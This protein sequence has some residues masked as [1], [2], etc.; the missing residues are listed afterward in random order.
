M[1]SFIKKIL[2]ANLFALLRK[3]W[4]LQHKVV[5][6][7]QQFKGNGITQQ[8]LTQQLINAGITQGTSVL[9]HSSL[10][11]LGY[12]ANGAHTVIQALQQAIGEEGTLLMPAFPAT[13]YNKDYLLT[14]PIFSY[15][16]TPSSM[17]TITEVFR[18]QYATHRSLH[19][20]D[21]VCAMGA[22][23]YYFTNTHLGQLTPYNAQSPFYKL[24]AA[25]GKILLLGVDLNS[26]TNFHTL[27][28]AVPNFK[29]PVYDAQE[30]TTTIIDANNAVHY[31]TTKVHNPVYSAQRK[32][33]AF[34]SKFLA[35][36]IMQKINLGNSISYV[37]DAQQ[38]HAWMLTNYTQH[39]ITLYTP[40]GL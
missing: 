40:Q 21:S 38:L 19:A 27:E 7:A 22:K 15:H 16:N 30:F 9:V 32:C 23:A 35:D 14:S 18:T 39:G 12:V 1:L 31:S 20:T 28:D 17:G 29:Y 10:R 6:Y 34:E 5:V 37:I 33:L 2:P 3:L 26:L 25:G 8:Q 4:R 36:G 24:C 11:K 13:G